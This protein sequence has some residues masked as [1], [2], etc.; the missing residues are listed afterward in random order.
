MNGRFGIQ[1][2][3]CTFSRKLNDKANGQNVKMIKGNKGAVGMFNHVIC[4]AKLEIDRVF[5]NLG[6]KV[7]QRMI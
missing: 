4:L 7:E 5:I 1:K 3:Q 2:P 6:E